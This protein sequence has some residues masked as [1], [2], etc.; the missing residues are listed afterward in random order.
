MTTK[1][2]SEYYL[3]RKSLPLAEKM[4]KGFHR[5]LLNL[6]MKKIPNLKQK[7]FF[8]VGVGWG[9]LAELCRADSIKF[10]GVE[11]NQAQTDKLRSLGYDVDCAQVPPFPKGEGADVIWLSHL[12]EH[13]DGFTQARELLLAAN[14]KLKAGGY[15]VIIS[16]DINSWKEAFWE[17][18]WSH[19]Y[20]TSVQRISQLLG[21]T[22]FKIHYA[23][24]ITTTLSASFLTLLLDL[25]Y[26][27]LPINL[28]DALSVRLTGKKLFFGYMATFGW[29]QAFVIGK[30]NDQTV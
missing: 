24:T 2:Y 14:E 6:A 11:L 18:D 1:Q 16:P 9:H 26:R 28:L 19:G 22:G 5:R 30:K 17:V 15:I 29:R 25:V 23:T 4:I 3:Q 12:L 8:E 7:S 10:R 27:L 13:M 20:P 21:D